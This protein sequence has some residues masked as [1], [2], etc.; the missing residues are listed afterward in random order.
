MRTFVDC[1]VRMPNLEVLEIFDISN[2]NL[3]NIERE[4]K[5][6][7]ARFPS[8][9]ELRFAAQFMESI[10]VIIQNCPN[11][12][13]ITV[14]EDS[15]SDIGT[16][17]SYGEGLKHL[18]RVV[19]VYPGDILRSKLRARS[20]SGRKCLLTDGTIKLQRASRIFRRSAL[21]VRPG[22]LT[23]RQQV[24][25]PRISDAHADGLLRRLKPV[26]SNTYAY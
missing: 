15:P 1:L 12:E 24:P 2:V 17:I 18:K 8:I 23:N 11:V 14:G 21:R 5:R 3:R 7:C 16:L 20:C 6:K 4:L 26:P 22:G 13:S 25:M 9:R 19:G 10:M